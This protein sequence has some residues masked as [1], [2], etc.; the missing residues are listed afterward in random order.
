MIE[1]AIEL[2]I[3][4][5]VARGDIERLYEAE[6]SRAP[7]GGAASSRSFGVRGM[8]LWHFYLER[9]ELNAQAISFGIRDELTVDEVRAFYE[10]NQAE[11]ERQDLIAIEVT[12]WA[13]GRALSS[14]EVTID[15]DTVRTMQE[16]DDAVISAALELAP[17]GRATVDRGDGRFAQL[18]CLS[19]EDGGVEPFDDVVQAASRQLAT[20]RFRTQ[21]E[22]RIDNPQ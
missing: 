5:P 4:E 12:E 6:L 18:E 10:Q 15:E 3:E 13:D 16:R 19:R 2:G 1:W 21:L 14:S 8:T 11:F 7:S 22:A 17:G 9:V 20:A